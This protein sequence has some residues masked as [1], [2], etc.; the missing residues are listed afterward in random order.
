MA[1]ERPCDRQAKI[2]GAALAQNRQAA[3]LFPEID[4]PVGKLTRW[5]QPRVNPTAPV[6]RQGKKTTFTITLPTQ[7]AIFVIHFTGREYGDDSDYHWR[8]YRDFRDIHGGERPPGLDKSIAPP[9]LGANDETMTLLIAMAEHDLAHYYRLEDK[10]TACRI[11]NEAISLTT[12]LWEKTKTPTPS[13]PRY[14][15]A[16]L[17]PEYSFLESKRIEDYIGDQAL[18][19]LYKQT[20]RAVSN[21][22]ARLAEIGFESGFGFSDIKPANMVENREGDILFIDVSRP[23]NQH[24]LSMLGQLYQGALNEAPK[25]CLLVEILREKALEILKAHKN[26]ELAVGLF[27]AGRMNRLLL[28]CTLRNIVWGAEVGS[29][30][31]QKLIRN[32]LVKVEELIGSRSPED[33]V[34]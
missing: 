20:Q 3:S 6:E 2:I 23:S 12:Y 21:Y 5:G 15:A 33:I 11:V 24:W 1:R 28:P 17:K 8:D 26:Q 16:F 30:T 25:K 9:L 4:T 14:A 18:V 7:E 29:Q 22:F 27:T 19:Q 34:R 10:E 13:F 32:C 31:D